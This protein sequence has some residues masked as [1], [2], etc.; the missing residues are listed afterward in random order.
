MQS[1]E[2]GGEVKEGGI[3][4]HCGH[5]GSRPD[6]LL[7]LQYFMMLIWDEWRGSTEENTKQL[8]TPAENL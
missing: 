8:E 3:G 6:C 2:G 1:A 4:V 7:Y 5:K